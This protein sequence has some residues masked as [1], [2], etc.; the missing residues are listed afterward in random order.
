MA[1][2]RF[3]IEN[4]NRVRRKLGEM[5][6]SCLLIDGSASF[7]DVPQVKASVVHLTRNLLS[8]S[9]TSIKLV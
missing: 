5:V 7:M 2:G 4:R 3:V 6:R 9:C 8:I 1:E